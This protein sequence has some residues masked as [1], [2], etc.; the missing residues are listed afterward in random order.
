MEFA[1][2]VAFAVVVWSLWRIVEVLERLSKQ[3]SAIQHQLTAIAT[4]GGLGKVIDA[5]RDMRG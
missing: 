1:W 5:I 4:S 2:V 3:L